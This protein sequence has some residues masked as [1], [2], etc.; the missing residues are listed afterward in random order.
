MDARVAGQL[1][2]E[3]GDDEPPVAQQHRLA[4]EL[5]EHFDVRSRVLHAR[6]SD[7]DAAQRCGI[8]VEHEICLE[9]RRLAAVRVSLHRDVDEAEVVAVEDDHARARAEHRPLERR[10]G[11]VEAVEAH[12]PHERRRL[13][14]WD[15]EPVQPV[16]LVRLAHFHDVGSQPPQHRRVL[17][18]IALHG[19]DADSHAR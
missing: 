15:D 5:G 10:D 2:V 7:E 9:A 11:S 6:G 19:K 14:A 4:V 12:E 17:A 18:E 1:R 13:A 16:E 8:P 3:R